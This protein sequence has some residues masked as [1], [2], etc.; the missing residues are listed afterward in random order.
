MIDRAEITARTER[1]YEEK[2]LENM[3]LREQRSAEVSEI[4]P[5]YARLDREISENGFKLVSL[6]AKGR[7]GT[8]EYRSAEEKLEELGRKR[9]AV[10]TGGGFPADYIDGC[11]SCSK[12]GDTGRIKDPDGLPVLCDCYREI[13]SRIILEESGLPVKKGFEAF[14][15]KV[16]AESDRPEAEKLLRD[17]QEFVNDFDNARSR[18]FFGKA[19]IGKTYLASLIGTELAK[20]GV[21]TVYVTVPHLM[22]TLLYYG[23]DDK[24]RE[25]R[26]RLYEIV[27]SADLL[28]LDEL[29]TER[30]TAARQ[31]MLEVIIDGIV[32]DPSR[33]CIVISN[34]DTREM[35][36]AYG[37]RMFS[38]LA[39]MKIVKF[40]LPATGDLRI[41]FRW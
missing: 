27:H 21:Y 26:D 31:D 7:R 6:A 15:A 10:L 33:K 35:M 2:R 23:D 16:F 5:E 39:S 9:D 40:N 22:Q 30:M 11:F 17:S 19:G 13:S 24:M 38:R 20:K 14:D 36:S 25:K 28:I 18:L 29:G 37:E 4:L 8:D 3:R 1:I 34:L 32:N 41:K 12:C